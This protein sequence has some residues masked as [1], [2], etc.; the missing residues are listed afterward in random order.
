MTCCDA[1]NELSHYVL[2]DIFYIELKYN[3]SELEHG[4][5]SQVT[6][7]LNVLERA[8]EGYMLRNNLLLFYNFVT[9]ILGV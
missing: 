2:S 3:K 4:L 7:D 1:L 8:L 5:K 9:G 6:L